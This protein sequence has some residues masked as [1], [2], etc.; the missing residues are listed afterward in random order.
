MKLV[1]G[2]IMMCVVYGVYLFLLCNVLIWISR[3]WFDEITDGGYEPF[4]KYADW[5]FSLEWTAP[6]CVWSAIIFVIHMFFSVMILFDHHTGMSGLEGFLFP[7]RAYWLIYPISLCAAYIGS[8]SLGKK[9]YRIKKDID[10]IKLSIK[11][12]GKKVPLKMEDINARIK[13]A[14]KDDNIYAYEDAINQMSELKAQE[15]DKE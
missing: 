8:I 15:Y 13:Q 11:K 10:G 3:V 9:A 6:F 2:V 7:M 1:L 12:T 4:D 14:K 5:F